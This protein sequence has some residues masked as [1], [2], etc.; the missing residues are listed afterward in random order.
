MILFDPMITFTNYST[1][2]PESGK[3]LQNE[4]IQLMLKAR[5]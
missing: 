4:G 3:P 1:E 2:I 5:V